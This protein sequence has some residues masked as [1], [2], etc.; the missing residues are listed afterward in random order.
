MAESLIPPLFLD[1]QNKFLFIKALNRSI[2]PV[3]GLSPPPCLNADSCL[4]CSTD[5]FSKAL[6]FCTCALKN[7]YKLLA[8]AIDSAVGT[9]QH[10]M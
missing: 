6:I 5:D 7:S 8:C 3:Y 9:R 10:E 4:S 1:A 2:L